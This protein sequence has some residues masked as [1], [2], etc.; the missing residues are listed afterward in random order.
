MNKG[1]L[2]IGNVD[3][4]VYH[5]SRSH[6]R[7][8]DFERTIET[9]WQFAY[10]GSA[11]IGYNRI[12]D[13][14]MKDCALSESF[15]MYLKQV[16]EFTVQNAERGAHRILMVIDG[17]D[18]IT[19]ERIWDYFPDPS[20]LAEGVHVLLTSRDPEA[21]NLPDEVSSRLNKLELDSSFT[22]G[23]HDNSNKEF[24]LKYLEK[25]EE[26]NKKATKLSADQ[27]YR[28]IEL[29]DNRILNLGMLYKLY[30]SGLDFLNLP[31]SDELIKTYLGSITQRY[32][33]KKS[34]QLYRILVVLC[35][36]GRYE[37]LSLHEIAHLCENGVV[38][39]EMIGI[40]NDL[41]AII[42]IERGVE[43]YG[44]HHLGD[45]RYRIVNDD[46]A[47]S[48][49]SNIPDTCSR[50]SDLIRNTLCAIDSLDIQS[51][52]DVTPQEA[53]LLVLAS[54]IHY[55][56]EE[57]ASL[58]SEIWNWLKTFDWRNVFKYLDYV[59]ANN[60]IN[61]YEHYLLYAKRLQMAFDCTLEAYCNLQNQSFSDRCVLDIYDRKAELAGETN[62][63][64]DEIELYKVILSNSESISIKD[65]AIY[66]SKIAKALVHLMLKQ[67]AMEYI[68]KAI[69]LLDNDKE[70]SSTEI[71]I[72][73]AELL[74]QK[75]TI[76]ANIKLFDKY[77]EALS[78]IKAAQGHLQSMYDNDELNNS[79][80]L[81]DCYEESAEIARSIGKIKEAEQAQERY[82]V[83]TKKLEVTVPESPHY[84]KELIAAFESG[85]MER[86]EKQINGYL[87]TINSF[88]THEE[89]NSYSLYLSLEVR[90]AS[91][92]KLRASYDLA[93]KTFKLQEVKK[94][95]KQR[96]ENNNY[97]CVQFAN[98]Y[99]QIWDML[100]EEEYS[101]AS[102]SLALCK[103]MKAHGQLFDSMDLVKQYLTIA[104][105]LSEKQHYEEA[106]GYVEYVQAEAERTLNKASL[107][108]IDT[109]IE[110]CCRCF[111]IV[112]SIPVESEINCTD[113]RNSV[114][115]SLLDETDILKEF[116]ET[117]Y[118]ALEKHTDV[119]I[120]IMKWMMQ[121][122]RPN[123]VVT[124]YNKALT[125]ISN[126]EKIGD[127]TCILLR[128]MLYKALS[129]LYLDHHKYRDAYRM[130]KRAKVCIELLA[131]DHISIEEYFKDMWVI[132]SIMAK[133]LTNLHRP[134]HA[135]VWTKRKEY[136]RR[137]QMKYRF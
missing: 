109:H 54:L 65:T 15:A 99:Q 51:W 72:L 112:L 116:A 42:H 62:C 117:N 108:F 20:V 80:L 128:I 130:A 95:R 35:L 88:T 103:R 1:P 53:E 100:Y 71:R 129:S 66:N 111:Q 6:L 18:E 14:K 90:R 41:S 107:K 61:H 85:N 46:V 59:A 106:L 43:V 94:T 12:A 67:D 82:I 75:A 86:V 135:W 83:M 124:Y 45:N 7:A 127:T 22:V 33:D 34:E 27:K 96:R 102:E 37:P 5:I 122:N 125:A 104:E 89:V 133:C 55:L 81:L 78:A 36:I 121:A 38:S 10:E 44:K 64:D 28:I 26:R 97:T 13:Y 56:K 30:S 69:V 118:K 101:L 119:C 105:L 77:D 136:Y 91:V 58:T 19:D 39:F 3:V 123:D 92:K 25:S 4:R 31:D 60:T 8:I 16:Q 17:L 9:L 49:I 74:M 73:K 24:L 76:I 79:Q 110:T 48:I 132:S 126:F 29:A 114:W 57:K 137:K 40:I 23:L 21:E 131:K 70:T 84:V 98:R 113:I 115:L 63:F 68:D 2:D 93:Y 32:G 87:N 50:F 52:E 47:K 11:W 120:S 134:L